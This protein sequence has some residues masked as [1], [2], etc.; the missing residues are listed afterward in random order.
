MSTNPYLNPSVSCAGPGCQH[1]TGD[2]K[3]W[4]ILRVTNQNESVG[5]LIQP[6]NFVLLAKRSDA[7]PVCGQACA[8]KLVANFLTTGVL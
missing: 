4:W 1:K 5:L 2:S 8:Q 6:F 3:S 7:K